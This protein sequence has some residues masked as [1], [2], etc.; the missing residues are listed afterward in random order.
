MKCFVFKVEDFIFTAFANSFDE[1]T[2]F[3]CGGGMN[4][5]LTRE[6]LIGVEEIEYGATGRFRLENTDARQSIQRDNT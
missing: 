6:H 5:G 3:I 2:S 1:A 4:K